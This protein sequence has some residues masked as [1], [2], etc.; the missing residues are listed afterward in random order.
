MI[1]IDHIVPGSPARLSSLPAPNPCIGREND[2]NAIINSLLE[3][4]SQAVALLGAGGIGKTTVALDV[5]W[6]GRVVTS[7]YKTRYFVECDGATTI[8]LLLHK[9]ATALGITLD[10][11]SRAGPTFIHIS[12]MRRRR[13]PGQLP[14]TAGNAPRRR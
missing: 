2:V 7:S 13:P 8:Q 12:R 3:P 9:L 1:S 6:D 5:L 14:G 11:G 10:H 4:G